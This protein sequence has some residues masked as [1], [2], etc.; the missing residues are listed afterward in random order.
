MRDEEWG[1]HGWSAETKLSLKGG[2]GGNWGGDWGGNGA[3]V[4]RKTPRCPRSFVCFWVLD[5]RCAV[6][7]FGFGFGYGYGFDGFGL[8]R[9]GLMAW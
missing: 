7:L 4:A 3:G 5:M 6:C 8:M 2:T 1:E 9:L